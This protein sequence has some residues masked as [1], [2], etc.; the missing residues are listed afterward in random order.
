MEERRCKIGEERQETKD[1]RDHKN[2][3]FFS[4]ESL[5][6]PSFYI[7]E[8]LAKREFKI[9]IYLVFFNFSKIVQTV[10]TKKIVKKCWGEF[11]L[12]FSF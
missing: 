3:Y 9:K 5:Q 7:K 4:S 8:Q 6:K 11:L 2:E 1:H 10:L 12:I